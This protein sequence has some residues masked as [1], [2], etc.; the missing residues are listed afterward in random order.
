[1]RSYFSLQTVL[2]YRLDKPYKL[3]LHIASAHQQ[4]MLQYNSG[5]LPHIIL[6]Y[7]V[8]PML[9]TLGNPFNTMKSFVPTA[10]VPP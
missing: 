3:G 2:R 4:Y 7:S 6:Y 5:F 1:M 8:D 9:P 10:N